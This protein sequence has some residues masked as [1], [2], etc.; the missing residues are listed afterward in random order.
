MFS[1]KIDAIFDGWNYDILESILTWCIYLFHYAMLYV[2]LKF[3]LTKYI[4][5]LITSLNTLDNCLETS[6]KVPD[7]GWVEDGYVSVFIRMYIR[8]ISHS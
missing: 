8:T 7:G 6:A 5:N 3:S 1:W 2:R 4:F